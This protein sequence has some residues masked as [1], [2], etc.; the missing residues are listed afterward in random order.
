MITV[1]PG[2]PNNSHHVSLTDGNKTVGLILCDNQGNISP[3]GISRAVVQRT[4][5]KTTSGEGKWGSYD[6]PWTPIAQEDFSGG[7]GK[8]DFDDDTS[9]FWTSRRCNSSFGKVFLGGQET[10]TTGYRNSDASLPGSVSWAALIDSRK[11]MAKRFAAGASYSAKSVYLFIRKRGEPTSNLYVQLCADNSGNPGTVIDTATIPSVDGPGG[12][13]TLL[14]FSDILAEFYRFD[15]V[16][17][18]AITSGTYYWIKIYPTASGT[19]SD[20]W[21]IG[22][23]SAGTTKQSADGTTWATSTMDLYYRLVDTDTGYRAKFFQY[24]GAQYAIY[25]H[26]GSAPKLFINGDRGAADANTGALSTLVDATKSWTTNQWAGAIVKIIKGTGASEETPYRTVSSNNGTTL[27]VSSPW[28]IEHDTTTEYVILNANSWTEITG[29]G[30]TG[31]V[32]DV[33]VVNDIIYLAQG[34]SIAIRRSRFYNN[35]GTWTAEYA[36]DSTNK[37]VYL[38]AVRNASGTLEIWRANNSDGSGNISVSMASVAAWGADLSFGSAFTVYDQWGRINGIE[39]YDQK[40]YVFREGT[41]MYCDGTVLAEIELGELHTMMEQ[42]NG[43]AHCVSNVYLLFNLGAG[44]ER[45]Y[46]DNL[47]DVGPNRDDGI[48]SELQGTI[49]SLLPYPGRYMAAIDG[50]SSNFSSV[51][52]HNGTGWHDV[53]RAPM[54]G[55]RILD[56]QFQAIPGTTLDRLWVSV[57]SDII[58]I[59]FPSM[60]LNPTNDSSYYYNHEGVLESGYLYAG[61]IDATKL[62][63]SMKLFSESLV[64]NGQF[65]SVDY[66]LDDETKWRTIPSSFFTSPM[67]E[68]NF[69]ARGVTGK[70]LRFRLRLETTDR[71]KTPVIKTTVVEAISRVPVR[72]SYQFAYRITDEDRDLNRNREQISAAKRQEII[73][74]WAENLT[75]LVMRCWH[76]LFDC[77]E[78]FIEP[79]QGAPIRE[80]FDGYIGRITL[81]ERGE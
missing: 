2:G 17:A 74:G 37:A 66:K 25:N 34:D 29:H 18:N 51:M 58:W 62:F 43:K 38:E 33:L 77:M 46:N 64:E 61:M 54:E 50:G 9:R 71:S 56:L 63:Q 1:K 6:M 31:V 28:L 10:Y 35:S 16:N 60:T 69:S 22:C 48:P 80:T 8:E 21:E 26:D 19:D 57:G 47:D 30:L 7:C 78:V 53:Y 15:F 12:G 79:V 23:K 55:E 36:A 68:I 40:L 42:S 39:A 59:P 65:V 76:I 3:T 67:K 13:G 52:M 4:A 20:H 70:R 14:A 5:L 49:S 11:Y 72:Y 32:T 73:D 75:P 24:K 41:V 44:I 45:W 81:I 27:T